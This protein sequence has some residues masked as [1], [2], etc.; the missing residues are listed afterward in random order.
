MI[1]NKRIL[2]AGGTGSLG[3]VLVERILS[4]SEGNPAKVI[5]LS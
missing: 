3:K 4:G 1:S 5:V 2:V